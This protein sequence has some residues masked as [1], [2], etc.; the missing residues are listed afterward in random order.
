MRNNAILFATRLLNGYGILKE[1][2]Y[3]HVG[4][5]FVGEGVEGEDALTPSK[6][7]RVDLERDVSSLFVCSPL[8][9]LGLKNFIFLLSVVSPLVE[10]LR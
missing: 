3:K 10:E 7:P 1:N 2:K 4:T 9:C 8:T 5:E 6:C